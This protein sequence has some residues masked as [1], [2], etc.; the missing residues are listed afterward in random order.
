VQEREVIVVGAG[1]V[2]LSAALALASIGHVPTVLEA[3][4]QGRARPGSRGIFVH[5]ESLR[6]LERFSPGLGKELIAHGLVWPTK[7][8]TYRGKEVFARTYPRFPPDRVPQFTS[9]PQVETERYLLAACA[10]AGVEFAWGSAVAGISVGEDGVRLTTQAASEWRAAYVVAADGARSAVRKGLRIEMDGSRSEGHYVVVDVAEDPA[11][12]LPLERVFHYQHPGIDDRNVLIVPFRGGWRI[13][14]QLH[15]GDNPE[16]FGSAEGVRRWLPRVM[17]AGYAERIG[18]VSTYQFLQIVARS[19]TDP[20]HRVLL[21]GEAAHLFAPFGARGMNSG[22]ADAD[23]AATAIHVA[24]AASNPARA[25]GAVAQFN[26]V[27]IAA[28]R[29]NRDAA[30]SALAHLR[31][32]RTLQARQQVAAALAPRV[33]RFGSWLEQAPYGPRTGSPASVTGR[34]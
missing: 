27:R 31:P 8:T 33:Q 23:A 12:P 2:G 18:W 32:S 16:E 22:M 30:G 5:G 26:A 15:E 3:E 6:L 7:R 20:A 29:F 17:P 14:L 24:L 19:F 9:L 25:R 21:A 1:P 34:Y 11:A 13:D 28:A 10:K 4:E